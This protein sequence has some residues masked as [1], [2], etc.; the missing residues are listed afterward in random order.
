M[1]LFASNY[2]YDKFLIVYNYI[3]SYYDE[4]IEYYYELCP[5]EDIELAEFECDEITGELK[6][7]SPTKNGDP[8]IIDNN[9]SIYKLSNRINI[10][11]FDS[12]VEDLCL[13]MKKEI[14]IK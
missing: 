9:L 6:V 5:N 3:K 13:N 7:F 12:I 10:D 8:D 14:G 11:K 4:Y 2:I 1:M